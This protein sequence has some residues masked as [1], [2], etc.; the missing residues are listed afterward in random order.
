MR[1]PYL[2]LLLGPRPS[3][4]FCLSSGLVI[5]L[6]ELFCWVSLDLWAGHLCTLSSIV[7]DGLS[8]I[9]FVNL[10]SSVD[11][12]YQAVVYSLTTSGYLLFPEI[13]IHILNKWN[14]WFVFEK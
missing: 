9:F 13:V 3:G 8:S 4:W 6:P 14:T 11:K 12:K 5:C 10:F 1:L 2:S 7:L